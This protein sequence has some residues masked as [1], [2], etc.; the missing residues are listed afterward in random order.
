MD[1]KEL[2][3]ILKGYR[4]D[5]KIKKGFKL[6]QRFK[7]GTEFLQQYSWTLFP[8][9]LYSKRQAVPMWPALPWDLG[10]CSKGILIR[11]FWV[12]SVIEDVNSVI[13]NVY[14]GSET[15]NVYNKYVFCYSE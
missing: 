13:E 7:G 8:V 15:I 2:Q 11:I 9:V 14:V 12:N 3:K 1:Y 4:D 5:G 10:I 6:N